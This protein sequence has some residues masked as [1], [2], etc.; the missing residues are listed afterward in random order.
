[1]VQH[2][3]LLEVAPPLLVLGRPWKRLWRS[4]PLPTRERLAG[5]LTRMPL[6]RPAAPAAR[7]P[8]P[9]AFVLMNGSF[10]L[11]HLPSLYDAALAN[12][13]LH[14]LE[15]V[16]FF[17]SG[18]CSSG[19]TCSATAPSSTRLTP[20]WRA[21][22]AVGSMIVGWGL[23]VVLATAPSPLYAHYADLASRPFGPLGARRPA[24]RRRA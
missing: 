24:A 2:M 4:L 8:S 22:Y 13:A 1:M 12:P 19:C 17:C 3:L 7:G 6:G 5:G 14:D 21:A 10:L 20:P 23:A 15:H 18:A 11:W 16:V 9:C